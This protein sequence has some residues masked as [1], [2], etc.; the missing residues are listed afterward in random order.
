VAVNGDAFERTLGG[1][2]LHLRPTKNTLWFNA[3]ATGALL[4][5][6]VTGNFKLTTAVKARRASDPSKP[7]GPTDYQFGGIMARAP[8]ASQ[9]NY[10]F[11]VVGDRGPT[12]QTE[13]KSTTNGESSV[14]GDDWPSGDAQLRLCRIGSTFHLY[15]RPY[16]GGTWKIAAQWGP[17]YERK[18][19][20]ATLQV[21]PIAYAWTD[22]PDLRAS[23]DY[24]RF[25]PAASE[26]DCTKD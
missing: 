24:V 13:T 18:D 5:K 2:E 26:A 21:G 16:D 6:P 14:K 25:E 10:V 23:F 7:V 9:E 1:G 19:L 20:P 12:I 17:P 4:Y 3:D 22:T 8:N 15:A 11:V